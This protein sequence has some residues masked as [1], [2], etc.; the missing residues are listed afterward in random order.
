[1]GSDVKL[2]R[3]YLSFVFSVIHKFSV[4]LIRQKHIIDFWIIK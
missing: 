1:M 4:N 3:V 2:R